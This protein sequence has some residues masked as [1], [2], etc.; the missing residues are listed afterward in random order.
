MTN[1]ALGYKGIY[2]IDVLLLV[3][4]ITYKILQ[5]QQRSRDEKVIIMLIT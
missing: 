4:S 2:P 1:F 3:S 5:I